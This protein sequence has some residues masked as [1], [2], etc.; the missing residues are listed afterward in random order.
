MRSKQAV[1]PPLSARAGPT[2]STGSAA[3][4]AK[5]QRHFLSIVPS[6]SARHQLRLQASAALDPRG[7]PRQIHHSRANSLLACYAEFRTRYIVALSAACVIIELSNVCLME[8]QLWWMSG[9]YTP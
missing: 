3:I 2:I 8:A 6:L 7:A 9:R 5:A 4:R 1:A